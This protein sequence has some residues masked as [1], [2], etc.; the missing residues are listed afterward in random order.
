VS[1]A[2]ELRKAVEAQED[3]VIFS[4]Y[5]EDVIRQLVQQQPN[6]SGTVVCENH[7]NEGR[8]E[9]LLCLK[10][11]DDVRFPGL[12]PWEQLRQEQSQVPGSV[13]VVFKTDERCVYRIFDTKE[14]ESSHAGQRREGNSRD[15]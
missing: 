1:E 15:V 9:V 7:P 10:P 2:D 4:P 5:L 13:I 3:Y 12:P 8:M 6:H 11:M 14:Q